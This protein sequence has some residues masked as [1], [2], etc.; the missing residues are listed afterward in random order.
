MPYKELSIDL[1][2]F[3]SVNLKKAGLYK[4]TESLDFEIILFAWAFDKEPVQIVEDFNKLPQEVK[5]ALTDREIKKTAFNALFEITAIE[6]GTDISLKPEQWQCTMVQCAMLGLPQ[7]LDS[8][9][10]AMKLDTTKDPKGKALLSFF[11]KPCKPTKKNGF[12]TRNFPRDHP[13]KWLEFKSYCKTDVIQERK[14]KQAL[15]FFRP[16]PIEQAIYALDHRINKRGI[17]IDTT[18]AVNALEMAAI[19]KELCM[20]RAIQLTGLSNPGSVAQIK[21]WMEAAIGEP[22]ESLNKKGLP[23]LKVKV[24]DTI[25]A[26]VLQL[27]IEISKTSVRKYDTM[28]ASLG[29]DGRTRGLVQYY[30]AG[31]TGRW[32]GRGVQVHNLPRN[33][34]KLLN[35]ARQMVLANDFDGVFMLWDSVHDV[36]SQL[37]RTAFIAAPGKM[38][39]PSDFSAIEARVTAWLAQEA[40]RLQ[41]FN[42]HGKIYEASAAAMFKVPIESI[43]KGS[44]LRQRGKVAELAL[45]FGGGPNA[46]IKMGAL[47]MR[48]PE[49]ELPKLVR[50]WRNASPKIAQYWK[51]VENCAIEAVFNPGVLIKHKSNITFQLHHDILWLTLPSGRALTYQSPKLIPGKYEGTWS[52]T[53][54]GVDQFTKRWERQTT[55]GGKLTENIV[56]AIARDLLAYAMLRLDSNG[57]NIVMHVHDEAVLEVDEKFAKS[58]IDIINKI[59]AEQPDWAKGLPLGAESFI[60][61]YYKKE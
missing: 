20:Q 13:E 26:E 27:R 53:Y 11:T 33:T 51:D 38:L 56:Q 57:F 44:D 10:R 16:Q 30:G 52:L 58:S 4:Y 46:L 1:E 37:I 39:I 60:T 23:A 29:D 40:W 14:I 24:K 48:I 5:D 32:A 35:E 34:M 55:Y 17:T 9:G 7:S 50:M 31:R 43:D 28:L 45:G 42:T 19:Q 22:I 36:L 2:T 8:A 54:L 41:T 47:D 59:M 6:A 49:K 12:K 25:A 18:L 21:G 15:S 3:S 61:K